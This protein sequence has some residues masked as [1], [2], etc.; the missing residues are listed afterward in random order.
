MQKRPK[1]GIFCFNSPDYERGCT[2]TT[3]YA[4]A[5]SIH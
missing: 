1:N 5:L 4:V 3:D 2:L